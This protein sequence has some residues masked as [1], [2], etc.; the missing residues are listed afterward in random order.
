MSDPDSAQRRRPPTIDLTAKEVET[1]RPADGAESSTASAASADNSTGQGSPSEHG[2][3]PAPGRKTPYIVGGLIGAAAGA[4]IIVGLWFAGLAPQGWS[5]APQRAATSPLAPASDSKRMSEIEVQLDKLR[6]AAQATPPDGGLTPRIA[7]V[8]TQTKALNDAIAALTRRVDE[9][10][11]ST[12]DLATEA[13]AAAAAA[14]AA[15]AEGKAAAQ[16]KEQSGDLDQIAKRIETL[17]NAVKTLSADTARAS[18]SADDHLARATAAAAALAAVVERGAP[19][20][21]ELASVTTLGADENATAALK[22]FAA[23]G[24]PSAAAL[25]RELVQL[26]PALRQASIAAPTESS[27][28]ARLELNAQKLVRITRTDSAPTGDDPSSIIARVDTD[29]RSDDIAGAL[30]DIARLPPQPRALA[31][32]WANKAQAREA[33]I[34]ASRR[35]A[36]EATAALGKPATQ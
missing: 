33:A 11:A 32:D 7:N 29:A 19:F 16:S 34:A 28:I 15:A 4:A 13:K 23:E 18:S 36:A 2:S 10:A 26:L 21:A 12:H 8:E 35:I 30:A 24:L 25:G 6:A 20:N 9:I 14:T 5:A 3:S 1:G 22:P 27:L 31:A 17:E